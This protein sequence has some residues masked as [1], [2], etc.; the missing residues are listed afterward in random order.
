MHSIFFRITFSLALASLGAFAA[1]LCRAEQP[2]DFARDIQPLLSENCFHCHGPDAANRAADLRLDQQDGAETMLT[3]GDREDSELFRRIAATDDDE[4]MPPPDSNRTLTAAQIELIGRWIDQGAPWGEHW[5]F[6]PLVRPDLPAPQPHTGDH[7]IDRFVL[8]MLERE[9]LEAA[10]RASPEAL[11]RRVSL[12]LTGLPPTLAELDAF[13]ADPSPSAYARAVDR[14]L[15]SPAYGERMAWD[16][17]DAARYADSNG[18]QGDGERTMWPWRDW[19]VEAFNRNL[20]LDQFTLWQLAGDLLPAATFEQKLATGFLRNHMINGEG[21]RIAE[22]NRVE[23]V[24]D[25]TETVGTLWMGLTLNCCRCHDHKFDPLT[26]RDYYQLFAFFNQTPVTGGGGNPQTPPVLAVPDPEQQRQLDELQTQLAQ[27]RQSLQQH[28]EQLEAARPQWEQ[29]TLA[30]L[31]SDSRWRAL[32]PTTY[33]AQSQDLTL[34]PDGSLLASGANPEQDTYSLTYA[35]PPSRVTGLRIEALRH[36]NMTAGGLA[37][38]DS[39]NFV[40]TSVDVVLQRDGKPAVPLKLVSGQASYEQG[41]FGISGVWDDNPTSGWAVYE[42]KP[43]DRDHEAVLVFAEP[44][45]VDS[46]VQFSVTLR[47][48]SRHQHHNLGRFRLSVTSDAEPALAG[49]DDQ[50]LAALRLAAE[51][52]SE[53][54]R[55]LLTEQQR[56]DDGRYGELTKAV[57]SLEQRL[58]AV[59]RGVPQVMIMGDQPER[60][61]TY[62]LQVGLYNKP[63]EEVQADVPGFLPDLPDGV[64]AD[65]LALAQWLIDDRNPLT[66]RVAVNRFW[67][68]LFGVGLVNTPE[69]F[70]IQGERPRYHELLDWLAADFRDNGWDVKALLRRIVTSRTYQ[71]ASA[72]TAASFERDPENRLLARGPRRR[73]PAWMLRDQALAISGLLAPQL[74]GKPVNGYQP[75]GI[76]E[77]ATFGQ[78]KYV[79]DHGSALH[80]RTLYTFWRRIVAPTM[81]FDNAPRQVC[82]VSPRLTNTPLHALTTLNETTYVEAAR[83]LAQRVLEAHS[84]PHERVVFAF[85]LAT[86]RVP[87]EPEIA[88]LLG[89]L[90]IL[91]DQFASD[92]DAAERLLAIG[93]SP[94]NQQLD[95]LDHAAWAALCSLILNLDETLTKP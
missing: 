22:E 21:G 3:P 78:K 24:F 74:G 35:L 25:M 4:L 23:Y 37:R 20:P 80:R 49:S 59:R 33:T 19:V 88:I 1:T 84:E 51:D 36:E 29:T 46:E 7:P 94:R 43:L 58:T 40:L 83:A 55:K 50:L 15:Q 34:L 82:S 12:D 79:Q 70:G 8:A 69:D 2:I 62:M 68:Q 30:R 65:R 14:L 16:W 75:P 90:Q 39:G 76:W 61:K 38:S 17:L 64:T 87:S 54:Q 85:R 32:L 5:A 95:P 67:Q 91:H 41:G 93:E 81:L 10:P 86:A 31:N 26:Q 77:E 71:Q 92:P 45:E 11:L 27:A 72:M 89:R 9:G 6:A 53:E 47:H 57:E 28:S 13:L 60:R 42:G 73:L 52:R 18:Y 66:A 56:R 63:G 44:V 48:E